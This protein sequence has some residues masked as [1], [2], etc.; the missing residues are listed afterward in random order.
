M[1]HIRIGLI[2]IF[3]L[4]LVIVVNA[5]NISSD[6]AGY[7]Q[8]GEC[9]ITNGTESHS[10]ISMNDV[11]PYFYIEGNEQS[12]IL[13]IEFLSY[14]SYP[15]DSVLVFSGKTNDSTFLVEISNLS[16]SNG[17]K[18]IELTVN[19]LKFYDGEALKPF[20][21]ERK[22]NL[23]DEEGKIISSRIY[24]EGTRNPVNNEDMCPVIAED[25]C[26]HP[27]PNY[28]EGQACIDQY[29]YQCE[30]AKQMFGNQ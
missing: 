26:Q 10:I 7:V 11:I 2:P 5:V 15:L 3:L 29:I 9:S 27:P 23:S 19:P 16:F 24:F 18:V 14:L 28:P 13:P 6:Y 22:Q 17:N 21:G 25:Y 20:I 30:E 1:Y 12:S 8:G 4:F